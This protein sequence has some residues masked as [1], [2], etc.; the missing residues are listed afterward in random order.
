MDGQSGDLI[1]KLS[2][3]REAV[4]EVAFSPDGKQ[5]VTASGDETARLYRF[6]S[7]RELLLILED[8]KIVRI[9]NT[10]H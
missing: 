2:G 8:S 7:L 5:I 1:L 4:H 9:K 10:S 3:H 6:V